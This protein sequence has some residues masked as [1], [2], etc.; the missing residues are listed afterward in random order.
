MLPS[1]LHSYF[2]FWPEC[3]VIIPG[4]QFVGLL[5]LACLPTHWGWA[6]KQ[7]SLFIGVMFRAKFHDV[8]NYGFCRLHFIFDFVA[9]L[10]VGVDHRTFSAAEHNKK[11][12][13]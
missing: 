10:S 7:P 12:T 13:F 6:P 9:D 8:L 3:D 11:L 5:F 4:L 1:L 2:G